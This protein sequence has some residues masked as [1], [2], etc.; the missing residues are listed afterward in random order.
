MASGR[1]ASQPGPQRLSKALTELIG[2]RGYA[3]PQGDAQ[4]QT[5]WASVAGRTIASETRAVAIRR[6]ILQVSVAHAPLL[7]ELAGFFRQQFVTQL[8]E[9]HAHLNI[10]DIKFKLDSGVGARNKGPARPA[11]EG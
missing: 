4:L 1:G 11:P 5:A 6:G 7:A 8:G 2:L 3:R 9:L 10:R